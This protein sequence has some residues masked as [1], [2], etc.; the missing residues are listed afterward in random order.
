MDF[1]EKLHTLRKDKNLSQEEL[2]RQ[3][4]VSRR[5]INSWE[6]EGRHP[7]DLRIYDSLSRILECPREYLLSDRPGLV[8][9]VYENFGMN[10]KHISKNILL[11]VQAY[12]MSNSISDEEKDTLMFAIHEAYIEAR[13]ASSDSWKKRRIKYPDF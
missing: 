13:K 9:D 5:T 4:H 8:S 1:S 10:R 6:H 12:F 3:L 7:K 11:D 2:A